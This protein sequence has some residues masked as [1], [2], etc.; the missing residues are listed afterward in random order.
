MM[1]IKEWHQGLRMFQKYQ[2]LKLSEFGENIR[3][4]EMVFCLLKVLKNEKKI[5]PRLRTD[6]TLLTYN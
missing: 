5:H 6:G 3:K 4:N 2:S 1:I